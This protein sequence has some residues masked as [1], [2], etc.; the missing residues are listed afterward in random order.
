MHILLAICIV[1]SV[2]TS[3]V[4]MVTQAR[5]LKCNYYSPIA[6]Q[7]STRNTVWLVSQLLTRG[8]LEIQSGVNLVSQFLTRGQLE[9][10]SGVNLVSLYRKD[11]L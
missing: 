11:S 1:P 7:G 6:N 10:Q 9:I 3:N 2:R 8:Q 5:L 4:C